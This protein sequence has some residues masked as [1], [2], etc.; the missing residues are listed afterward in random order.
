[1]GLQCYY[2]IE[3]NN[4]KKYKIDIP[5]WKNMPKNIDADDRAVWNE[6]ITKLKKHEEGHK[7]IIQDLNKLFKGKNFS[8]N[9]RDCDSRTVA[10]NNA[11][12]SAKMKLVEARNKLHSDYHKRVGKGPCLIKVEGSGLVFYKVGECE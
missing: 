3:K 7:R 10:E 2:Q 9:G 4:S 5:V 6:F 1:M 12:K 8:G 11:I